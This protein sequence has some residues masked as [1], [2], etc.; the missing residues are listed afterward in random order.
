MER[1]QRP[2]VLDP[3]EISRRL[4][5]E[6]LQWRLEDGELVKE[7]SGDDF[8]SSLRYVNQVGAIA[9]ELDHH[10]DIAISWNRVTLAVSTHSAGGI[11]KL[12]LELARRVDA[13]DALGSPD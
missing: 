1:S 8:A 11:T 13:L 10:P 5:A 4:A 6:G 3:A 2:E 9:E 12:D 7:V